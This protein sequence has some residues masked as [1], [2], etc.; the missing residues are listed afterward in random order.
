MADS[1]LSWFSRAVA[2]AKTSAV[3]TNLA[4]LVVVASV[5]IVY[6]AVFFESTI[7]K[8]LTYGKIWVDS[9]EIY[10][11]ERLVNDR[12]LHD[13]WLRRFLYIND[14]QG[15][16][17][18][19]AQALSTALG[20][21]DGNPVE[22]HL[23]S[24]IPDAEGINQPRV[25]ARDKFIDQVDFR[26]QV[27][28]LMIENQLDDR[29]DLYGNS[30]YRLKFDATIAPG[31]NTQATSRIT[32]RMTGPKFSN[33]SELSAQ[34]K[35]D[36]QPA[37]FFDTTKDLDQWRVV[38]SNWL[39]SLQTRLNQTHQELKQGFLNNEFSH[40]EYARFIRFLD[41][42]PQIKK[43][44]R[45][46]I[47]V[48]SQDEGQLGPTQHLAHKLC[49]DQIILQLSKPTISND[50]VTKGHQQ[51]EYI[52]LSTT[53]ETSHE[54]DPTRPLSNF[55]E[56]PNLS[57]SRELEEQLDHKL[58]SYFG[59]KTVQL[60]LGIAVPEITFVGNYFFNVPALEP[61]IELS[62]FIANTSSVDGEV[63]KVPPKIFTIV[64]IDNSVTQE[65][66]DQLKKT[67]GQLVRKAFV[68][69][70]VELDNGLKVSAR[71]LE[72]L[73]EEGYS[74]T[75][76]DFRPTQSKGV[77]LAV[78]E[79]GLMH[80]ARKARMHSQAYSYAVTPKENSDTLLSTLSLGSRI[81]GSLSDLSAL[82]SNIGLRLQRQDFAK[83]LNR[84]GTVVGFGSVADEDTS[85]EFGWVI[86]P[87]LVVQHGGD[88]EM[89]HS[90]AQHSL[91][92]LVSIPS[93]W[94]ILTLEVRTSW[95]DGDGV[96][97]HSANS[98]KYVVDVPTDFEPLEATLLG[99][100]QLGP[101]LMES[102]LDPIRL[103]A[104]RRGAILIPG[105]R[106][107]RST[108]VTLGFQTADEIT[109]LPNM[110]GI[111]AKFD[112]VENQASVL[113]ERQRD[114]HDVLEINRVVRLWTSQGTIALPKLARIGIPPKCSATDKG[115]F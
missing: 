89:I 19:R 72:P 85:V 60:V 45:D 77:Y 46:M 33:I 22:V 82:G 92:A 101:E 96:T 37:D 48:R 79:I 75:E 65:R 111:I 7:R 109:V 62:F 34:R 70:D 35:R 15:A 6:F 23:P 115:K 104:C 4:F 24:R 47:E 52:E 83:A 81:S 74:L 102:R 95:V 14:A 93:W 16:L 28:N 38:Y 73:T 63:F 51:S 17:Q 54:I 3:R 97:E 40:N 94:N 91:S 25:S 30:L 2:S 53:D 64:G 9:P 90:P 107:W 110:K 13:A 29:H 42:N 80:F 8:E 68:D 67:Q 27:R 44:T 76:T 103:T 105:R 21:I 41:T 1:F 71:E 98:V 50:P 99:V 11:R 78:A 88:F 58:N 10:T 112:T 49:I 59:S 26:D 84:R 5:V 32:V 113:E 86:G 87:R 100:Q 106:L 12:F 69:F 57:R 66:F 20:V 55:A 114:D 108:V 43:C 39:E 18:V 36:L 56:A 31:Q 61:L